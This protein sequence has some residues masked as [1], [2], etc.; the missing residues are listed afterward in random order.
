MKNKITPESP[1]VL[2]R[3]FDA[4][5]HHDI[6]TPEE[7]AHRLKVPVSWVYEK[8][9]TSC[10][11][12]IPLIR[13]GRYIRFNWRQILEWLAEQSSNNGSTR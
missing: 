9:R 13:I 1:N 2:A 6:L 5:H 4:V 10:V 3:K 12:P 8:T 11:N 7:L